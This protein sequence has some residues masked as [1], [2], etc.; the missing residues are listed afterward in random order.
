[1]VVF[2]RSFLY[3][4]WIPPP[5][6]TIHFHQRSSIQ[7]TSPSCITVW[8][9]YACTVCSMHARIHSRK[10]KNTESF[11]SE[12]NVRENLGNEVCNSVVSIFKSLVFFMHP[13]FVYLLVCITAIFI[14]TITFDLRWVQ[15]SYQVCAPFG[16]Y[17]HMTFR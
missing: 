7:C 8:A 13:V 6:Q 3:I 14:L 15:L 5:V 1:M 16:K 12:E 9:S 17:F 11:L 2:L 10:P 4:S